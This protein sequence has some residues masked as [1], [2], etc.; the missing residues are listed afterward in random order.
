MEEAREVTLTD[1]FYLG[2]FEVTRDQIC[3]SVE[4]TGYQTPPKL[5][6][7]GKGWDSAAQKFVCADKLFSWRDRVL[8]FHT[9]EHPVANVAIDDARKFCDWLQH[10]SGGPALLREIRLPGE[11]E[12]ISPAA[13]ARRPSF[14]SVTTRK[15][16]SNT[17][18][19]TWPTT[20]PAKSP[21]RP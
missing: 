13:P 14:S 2:Q 10:R 21:L 17:R 18:T 15:R 20:A 8:H 4:E 9:D 5:T 6:D 7:G 11:A 12:W 16:S 1:D 3:R 19:R